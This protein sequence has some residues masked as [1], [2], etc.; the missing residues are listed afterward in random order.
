MSVNDANFKIS[1]LESAHLRR[2]RG[3]ECGSERCKETVRHVSEPTHLH[4]LGF[5]KVEAIRVKIPLD[6]VH[7]G[8]QIEEEVVR[9]LR[10]QVPCTEN[11]LHLVRNQHLLKLCA[12]RGVRGG[13]G[14][15]SRKKK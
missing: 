13:G 15:G 6:T 2:V 14:K 7:V 1:Q 8:G 5:R 11:V 12:R 4:N 9:I 10:S 3:G